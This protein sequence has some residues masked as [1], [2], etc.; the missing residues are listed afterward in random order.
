[1]IIIIYSTYIMLLAERSLRLMPSIEVKLLII[2]IFVS[3]PIH[4][5]EVGS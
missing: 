3:I 1:M 5:K 4:F 2:I